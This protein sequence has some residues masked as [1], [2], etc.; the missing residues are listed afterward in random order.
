[1]YLSLGAPR[2]HHAPLVS[3][4]QSPGWSTPSRVR[5]GLL[6]DLQRA[7]HALKVPLVPATSRSRAPPGSP[8]STAANR[9]S[10]APGA[11]FASAACRRFVLREH[12]L[13]W[14]RLRASS[15]RSGHSAAPRQPRPYHATAQESLQPPQVRPP[16]TAQLQLATIR[17]HRTVRLLAWPVPTLKRL[18]IARACHVPSTPTAPMWGPSHLSRARCLA[19]RSAPSFA[20][21][22]LQLWP[23]TTTMPQC[24]QR[25]VPPDPSV[26]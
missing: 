8:L 5:H 21:R 14:G 16:A 11:G 12:T 24:C 22:S 25:N 17:I 23:T 20:A 4:V 6:A 26:Q 19:L 15:V 3:C 7:L 2:R 13:P 1:M 9:A 10:P 18:G